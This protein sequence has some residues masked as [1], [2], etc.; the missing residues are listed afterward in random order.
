MRFANTY[1]LQTAMPMYPTRLKSAVSSDSSVSVGLVAFGGG[2]E[3]FGSGIRK[4][5]F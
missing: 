4:N 5:I 3:N 1:M 2:P